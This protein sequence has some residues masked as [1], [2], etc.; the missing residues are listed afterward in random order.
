MSYVHME[1]L[2]ASGGLAPKFTTDQVQVRIY[3]KR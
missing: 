1:S 2:A 3:Y